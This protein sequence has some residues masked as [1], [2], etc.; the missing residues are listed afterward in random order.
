MSEPFDYRSL[1]YISPN[2]FAI[3]RDR[4][5]ILSKDERFVIGQRVGLSEGDVNKIVRRYCDRRQ[6]TND[7]VID[8][9]DPS[10]KGGRNLAG[11][12]PI[13]SRTPLALMGKSVGR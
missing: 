9:D 4:P 7:G 8:E 5:T 1:M 3:D 13:A 12:D 10:D 2:A 6:S 11:S